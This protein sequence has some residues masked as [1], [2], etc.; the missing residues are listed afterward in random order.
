MGHYKSHVIN[1]CIS[2]IKPY[3]G[4]IDE[5]KTIAKKDPQLAR[6][7]T[8]EL[9]TILPNKYQSYLDFGFKSGIHEVELY[10]KVVDQL[11]DPVVGAE[12]RY[13]VG[14]RFLASVEA[15]QSAFSPFEIRMQLVNSF[16][17]EFLIFTSM[18][19]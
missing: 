14:G 10:G 6:D 17:A 4:K 18:D 8:K 15:T 9:I 11:G 7:K 1:H 16:S 12:V 5:I 19:F 3:V 13:M 2:L